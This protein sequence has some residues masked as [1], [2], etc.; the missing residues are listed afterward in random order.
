MGRPLVGALLSFPL[1]A[2]ARIVE[3][4]GAM[5]ILFV[6]RDTQKIAEAERILRPFGVQVHGIEEGIEEIQTP[7]LCKLVRHKLLQAFQKVRRP[8]MV[9][10]TALYLRCLNGFPGGL[11]QSFWKTLGPDRFVRLFGSQEDPGML[12]RTIV[13]HCDGR[14]IFYASGTLRGRIAPESRGTA[15]FGWDCVFIP[16]GHDQTL[17]EMPPEMKD[18]LSMRRKA[19]EAWVRKLSAQKK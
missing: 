19:L 1:P 5:D 2:H 9:E 7:S 16:E 15:G 11:A 12:A 8:V 3:Y 4:G 17:A 6:S 18:E 13:G 14:K 10:H